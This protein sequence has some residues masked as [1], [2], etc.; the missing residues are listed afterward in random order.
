MDQC[1]GIYR[2]PPE[3]SHGSGY[4]IYRTP[5][6]PSHGS[7]YGIYRT[8]SEPSHMGQGHRMESS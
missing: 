5:S 2:T 4:G 6:E 7:G 3:P 1:H 8:P